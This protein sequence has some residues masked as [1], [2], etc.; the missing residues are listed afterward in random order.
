VW[1]KPARQGSGVALLAAAL[2][3]ACSGGKSGGDKARPPGALI[4][5][6]YDPSEIIPADLDLVLRIDVARMRSGIGP[7][8]AADLSA[9]ALKGAGDDVLKGALSCADVLWF[10][11]RLG[12]LDGA[13]HVVVVEGKGCAPSLEPPV[14]KKGSS[15][16]REVTIFDHEGDSV[17]RAGTA[18]VV[19]LGARTTAFVS[20]VERDSVS[21]VLRDGP[22]NLRGNPTA[23]GLLSVDVRASRL[24]PALERK[25]PRIGAIVAGLERLRGTVTLVDEG[26]QID[27]QILSPTERGAE[28]ARRF[29]ETLRDNVADPRLA[30]VMKSVRIEQIERTVRVRVVVPAKI[31]LALLSSEGAP[32]EATPVEKPK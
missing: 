1:S 7:A 19:I 5:R 17:P 8:A 14:W 21:R 4:A 27:A 31:V 12:D 24:P 13:D 11:A 20:P 18:K 22:D 32:S 16:N 25:F 3:V 29:L 10:G 15:T 6:R 28:K 9:R 2:L 26:L 23:E 30:G